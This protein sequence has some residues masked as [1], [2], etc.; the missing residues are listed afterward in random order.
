MSKKIYVCYAPSG[1]HLGNCFLGACRT[2]SRA[3][4][5][6][7]KRG[8]YNVFDKLEE[9]VEEFPYWEEDIML[10]L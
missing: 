5:L 7:G 8:Y 10:D 3:K 6:A 1:V 2:E 4:K 9:A